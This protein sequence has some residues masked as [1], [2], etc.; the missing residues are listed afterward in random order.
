V[1]LR[2]LLVLVQMLVLVLKP[3]RVRASEREI[4]AIV[5]L[6]GAA[7]RPPPARAPCVRA[8]APV[9]TPRYR[10]TLGSPPRRARPAR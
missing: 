8:R 5:L 10:R 4:A 3:S 2:F 7:L 6:C 1:L 9:A